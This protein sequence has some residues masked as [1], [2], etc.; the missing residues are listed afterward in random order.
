MFSS[1]N[2]PR[3]N[4]LWSQKRKLWEK[5]LSIFSA[6]TQTNHEKIMS[7]KR[8]RKKKRPFKFSN[9]NAR[10]CLVRF[11][12]GGSGGGIEKLIPFEICKLNLDNELI[13]FTRCQLRPTVVL[14]VGFKISCAVIA[15]DCSRYPI[16]CFFLRQSGQTKYRMNRI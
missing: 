2:P 4:F 6:L 13:V 8:A 3:L 16:G 12:K 15:T 1:H 9:L 11:P 5:Y 10:I 14:R 7:K